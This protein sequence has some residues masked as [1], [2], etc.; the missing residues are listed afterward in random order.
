MTRVSKDAT[1]VTR[2][3]ELDKGAASGLAIEAVCGNED[4][5]HVPVATEVAA[6]VHVTGAWRHVI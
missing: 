5:C 3:R 6:E 4:V 1:G 2:A